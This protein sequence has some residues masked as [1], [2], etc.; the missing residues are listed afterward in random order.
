[1]HW[2]DSYTSSRMKHARSRCEIFQFQIDIKITDLA[3]QWYSYNSSKC[4]Y[5]I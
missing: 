2:N 5:F 4:G 3:D 1:M